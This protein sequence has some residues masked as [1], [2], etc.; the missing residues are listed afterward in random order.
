MATDAVPHKESVVRTLGRLGRGAPPRG[1]LF[2]AQDFL[3]Q[4][5]PDARGDYVTQLDLAAGRMGLSAV[6]VD[7]NRGPACSLLVDGRY[8]ELQ[9]Y[10][11]IGCVNGP[12]SRLIDGLGFAKAMTWIGKNRGAGEPLAAFSRT[13]ED[14]TARTCDLARASGFSAIALAD[15]IA[16]NRGLLFSY[17]D[18]VGTFLPLYARMAE[19]IKEHGLYAFFHCDGDTRTIIDCLTRAGYDCIHPVDDQAGMDLGRLT[20]DFGDRLSFMGHIDTVAWDA[21]RVSR[22]VERA[23]RGFDEG[24]LILGSSGGVSRGTLTGGMVALYP[25]I[26]GL[27]IPEL[28]RAEG[29]SEEEACTE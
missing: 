3:D 1:E 2:L 17:D 25:G 14:G 8:G 27:P 23:A 10:F 7:L 24:G 4:G 26:R 28:E 9:D 6:G 15:D 13:M 21:P 5:F 20:S 11:L 22:E 19:T 12:V 29:R 18:F 16:G